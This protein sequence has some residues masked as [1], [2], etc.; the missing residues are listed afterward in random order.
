MSNHGL[1]L[2]EVELEFLMQIGFDLAFDCFCLFFRPN[3]SDEPIIRISHIL[4]SSVVRVGWVNRRELLC[5][6][7]HFIR[8]LV[9]PFLPELR[10]FVQEFSVRWIV[11]SSF[12]FLVCWLKMAFHVLIEFIEVDIRKNGATN[13]SLR[14]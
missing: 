9:L 1:F 7:S 12:S 2:G 11:S 13:S 3:E 10:N 4:E 5:C 8:L 14:G 6:F